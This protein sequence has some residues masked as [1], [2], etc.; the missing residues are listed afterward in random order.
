MHLN[1]KWQFGI[2]FVVLRLDILLADGGEDPLVVA[3]HD[4]YATRFRKNET[5]S[6][7]FIWL[8]F[9]DVF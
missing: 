1:L 8:E 5:E 7:K 3:G 9:A 6:I 2:N 4:E